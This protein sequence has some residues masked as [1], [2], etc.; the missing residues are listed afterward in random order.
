M[1]CLIKGEPSLCVLDHHYL[2][3][4]TG[5]APFV[6]WGIF[7]GAVQNP[8]AACNRPL[9]L[10]PECKCHGSQNKEERDRVIPLHLLAQIQPRKHD[11]HR[12]RDYF[13]NNFEL[14]CGELSIAK[15]VCRHL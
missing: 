10:A 9:Q 7:E 14:K 4:A 5:F 11:K 12:Q 15:P 3:D 1:S 6:E 2:S 13:L 8:P